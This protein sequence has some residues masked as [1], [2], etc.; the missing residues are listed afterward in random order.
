M[1][2]I[3]MIAAMAKN[4]V[5]GDGKGMPWKLSKEMAYFKKTTM[6]KP[7]ILGRKTFQTFGEKPLL[8]RPHIIVTRNKNYAPKGVQ[9]AH[10]VEEAL[11]LAKTLT[12]DEIMVIGGAEIYNQ[13]L[14]FCTRIYLTE[15]DVEAGGEILFPEFNKAIFK[16]VSRKH[17][18][19]ENINYDF[20][21][22]E[23]E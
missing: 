1:P 9:V 2:I 13:A 12:I 15:I 18:S 6:G 3:S 8:G 14:K 22:Y 11:T 16:E 17:E 21:I 19:E 20:V 7:L 10:S 4:R 23:K 5:I